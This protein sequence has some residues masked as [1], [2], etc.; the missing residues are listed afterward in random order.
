MEKMPPIEVFAGLDAV[1]SSAIEVPGLPSR[2]E[3]KQ[4]LVDHDAIEKETEVFDSGEMR[5]L[6]K[7]TK[8]AS[9][10]YMLGLAYSRRCHSCGATKPIS[11]RHGPHRNH[12]HDYI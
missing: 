7:F 12:P 9:I 2:E 6:K 8:G 3:L 4:W 5:K 10:V 1:R 11:R